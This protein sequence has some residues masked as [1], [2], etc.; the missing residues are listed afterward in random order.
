[1]ADPTNL[2]A[3]ER[4]NAMSGASIQ[5]G[6]ALFAAAVVKVYVDQAFT[7]EA[8]GWSSIAAML[9]WLGW[10]LLGLLETEN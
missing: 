10:K 2:R 7:W 4:F 6:T 1:M 8:G 3:N 9:I 5:L